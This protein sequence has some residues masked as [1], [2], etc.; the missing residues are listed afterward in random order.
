MSSVRQKRYDDNRVYRAE[1]LAKRFR[2]LGDLLGRNAERLGHC[3]PRQVVGRS[4]ETAGDDDHAVAHHLHAE[5]LGH[6]VD[7]V[8]HGDEELHLEP[9]LGEPAR[10]PGGV[11]GLDVAEDD[12][13]SDREHDCGRRRRHPREYRSVLTALTTGTPSTQST[14]LTPP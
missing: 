4:A 10:H 11:G 6:L 3:L 5:E 2:E 13:V 9:E 14:T 8:A 7:G 12:L 1:A